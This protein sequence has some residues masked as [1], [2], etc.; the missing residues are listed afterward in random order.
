MNNTHPLDGRHHETMPGANGSKPRRSPYARIL[1]LLTGLASSL[2]LLRLLCPPP[3]PMPDVPVGPGPAI[4]ATPTLI[5]N[6]V[7][8][9]PNPEAPSLGLR[10]GDR[11][12]YRFFQ[13]RSLQ[14]RG[15]SFG[16]LV[17]GETNQSV[18][19]NVR[20]DGNLIVNVYD[21]AEPGWV[22]GFSLENAR[23]QM[24]TATKVAPSDGSEAGLRTE[25]L[26][27]VARSGR[28]EKMTSKDQAPDKT[29]N[30]WRDILSRWQT[31]LS[32]DPAVKTW[33]QTE[34]DTTGT[35]VA[36]YSRD[37]GRPSAVIRKEKRQYVKVGGA[38][39]GG[40]QGRS[41]V[42]GTATIVMNPYPTHIEGSEELTIVAPEI[43]GGAV[44][45]AEYAFHLESVTRAPE[46]VRG[47]KG[48]V[49]WL[50]TGGI[51]FAWASKNTLTRATLNTD[52]E[53]TTIN[54]QLVGL[55][56]LLAAGQ[57][58][59]PAEVKILEKI[60]ALIRKD[61]AAVN[62]IME[63]LDRSNAAEKGDLAP[64]LIGMLGAAGTTKAQETLIGIVN[65]PERPL[66][67]REMAAF[68]F[69]QVTEP[70][71]EVDE[72]LR[73]LHQKHDE[74]SNSSLLVLGAMGDRVR[75]QDPARFQIIAEYVTAAANAPGMDINEQVVGLATIENLGPKEVPEV[76]RNAL[77]SSDPFLR[78]KALSSLKRVTDDD[79]YSIIRDSLQTDTSEG[80]RAAAAA[81]LGNPRWAGG[82]E[83]LGK[84]V[85]K[86]RSESVRVA[87]V[88]SLG[89][90]MG[91]NPQADRILQQ[92][93]SQDPSQDVRK[94]A[95]QMIGS[96]NSFEVNDVVAQAPLP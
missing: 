66:A 56:Q 4:P 50:E 14:L 3:T 45:K 13:D 22:V 55:E 53:G 52:I 38:K 23:V 61:D 81:L 21:E 34:E 75:E 87:A 91:S 35:Y 33:N 8:S 85:I 43:D 90:W 37:A 11:L 82:L 48:A 79:A 77:A 68:S 89:E 69:A 6:G 44:S 92:V 96:R 17:K 24:A 60:V 16:G 2:L 95:S 88:Q 80:V 46:L 20:Q 93:A 18:T 65:T 72:W 27:F 54:E 32:D 47:A 71:P 78:E 25:I 83:D 51:P 63:R 70:I 94:A 76:V 1:L 49:R 84:V 74:L 10:K 57:N 62:A 59:T 86:D 26:A 40:L 39:Q 58:G 15:C 73:Q 12:V 41:K 9:K 42:S 29:L 7:P 19:L 36:V 28:I 64:A 31:V 30:H 5:A 67:Q